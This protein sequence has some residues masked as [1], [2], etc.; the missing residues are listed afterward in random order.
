MNSVK[1]LYEKS[2]NGLIEELKKRGFQYDQRTVPQRG[3]FNGNIELYI[4]DD[5]SVRTKIPIATNKK[6]TKFID[7]IVDYAVYQYDALIA[8]VDRKLLERTIEKTPN[9]ILGGSPNYG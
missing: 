7:H 2:K 4:D 9:Y 6:K 5:Y 3:W 1:E 8:W